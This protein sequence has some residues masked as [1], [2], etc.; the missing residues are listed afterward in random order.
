[1]SQRRHRSS[2]YV[3]APTRAGGV[4]DFKVAGAVSGG[5]L[6]VW[7]CLKSDVLHGLANYHLSHHGHRFVVGGPVVPLR[8][9]SVADNVARNPNGTRR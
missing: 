9:V 6:T 3:A 4:A 8:P 1:M 7:Q 2:Q 5:L